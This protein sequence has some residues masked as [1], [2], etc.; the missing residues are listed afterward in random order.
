M[1][2]LTFYSI[3]LLV[4]ASIYHPSKAQSRK[5][6]RPVTYEEL[7]DDPYTINR[8]FIGFQPIYGE[9]FVANVNAGFGVEARY[10]WKE[11][12]NFMAHFRKT[13]NAATDMSRDLAEKNS[14][15]FMEPNVFNY[16]ELG[17]TYH[18]KDFDQSS[19]TKM[20]LYR[21]SYKGN[22]WASRVPLNAEIPC[23][24]RKIYGGRLGGIYFDTTTELN[25][26]FDAQ[27]ISHEDFI[28]KE[29]GT[30]LP[31]TIVGEGG[32]ERPL[33]VFGNMS[34][35]AIYAGG[36]MS[37]IKNV[38]VDFDKY[39]E[40]VDDL[41]LTVF[42][43]VIVA[44][45]VNVDDI[46]YRDTDPVS[47]ELRTRT[48]ASDPLNTSIIGFRAGL[49]GRFNRTLSWAYGGEVG[50]RPGLQGRS[51]YA[52]IKISFPVYSTNLDYS[53]EAFGK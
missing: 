9:L 2:K 26:A 19:K 25:R 36:S 41:I 11:K 37:W 44:P 32:E 38:A 29:D 42:L 7:Y 46:M 50:M 22:R 15:I 34:V 14:D 4:L 18:I 5:D 47:G 45:N 49:D 53:V 30:S 40:G 23:T 51:F 43:D 35:P 10:F 1:K 31:S 13:Y 20:F 52:L 21:K 28:S 17:A 8:L 39:E 24:V 48:Y 16:F 27:D 33:R 6:K 12:M 3:I